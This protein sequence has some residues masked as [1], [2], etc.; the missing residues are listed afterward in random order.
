MICK[1]Y[2]NEAVNNEK[3]EKCAG[4]H[5]RPGLALSLT[6]HRKGLQSLSSAQCSLFHS[7][8]LI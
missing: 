5:L 7:R 1:L 2:L 3:K 4:D 8:R 6:I